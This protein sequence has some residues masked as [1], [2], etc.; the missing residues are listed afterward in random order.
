MKKI[1]FF[2][3]ICVALGACN[4][5]PDSTSTLQQLK[6]QGQMEDSVIYLEKLVQK[7]LVRLQ[8]EL[9]SDQNTLDSVATGRWTVIK[10]N[11]K[12]FLIARK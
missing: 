10:K 9:Q 3:A 12:Y 8:T 6:L 5:T 2:A 11:E 1:L 4:T 7:N